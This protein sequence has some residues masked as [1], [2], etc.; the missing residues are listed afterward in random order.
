MTDKEIQQDLWHVLLFVSITEV[1][2]ESDELYVTPMHYP[3]EPLSLV[4]NVPSVS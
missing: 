3:S 2:L 4:W 1:I